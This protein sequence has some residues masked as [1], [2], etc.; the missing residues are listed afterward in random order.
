MRKK[1]F[2]KII[3]VLVIILSLSLS[4]FSFA[5]DESNNENLDGN[6]IFCGFYN[7]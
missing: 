5:S 7:G 3:F 4:L 1:L 6:I 2:V